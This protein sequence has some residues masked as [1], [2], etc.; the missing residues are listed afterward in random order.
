RWAP[1]TRV[2]RRHRAAAPTYLEVLTFEIHVAMK[3]RREVFKGLQMHPSSRNYAPRVVSQRSR[4][5][6]L[7]DLG[8]KSPVPHNL[9]AAVA[10]TRL[11]CWRV[12]LRPAKPAE[13]ARVLFRSGRPSRPL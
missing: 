1:E 8:T 7:E 10:M 5:V 11:P 2:N 6:R 9:P 13:F 12:R 4:L 3:D